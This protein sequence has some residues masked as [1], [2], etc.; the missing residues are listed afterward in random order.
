LAGV[1]HVVGRFTVGSGEQGVR[2]GVRGV[3]GYLGGGVNARR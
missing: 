1:G 3:A 2:L